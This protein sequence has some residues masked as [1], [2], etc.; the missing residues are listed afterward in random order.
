MWQHHEINNKY[1]KKKEED[2]RGKRKEERRNERKN[3][4]QCDSIMKSTTNTRG[5][6]KRT[7]EGNEKKKEETKKKLGRV[8]FF[9]RCQLI[10][11]VL[12][13]FLFHF[14]CL[15][16]I[17][18]TG[19]RSTQNDLLRWK[20]DEVE[21]ESEV[22]C[23]RWVGRRCADVTAGVLCAR[24]VGRRCADVTAGVQRSSC[25]PKRL[26]GMSLL[27][28]EHWHNLSTILKRC[29]ESY[30]SLFSLYCF[31]KGLSSCKN[32]VESNS[33]NPQSTV[34]IRICCVLRVLNP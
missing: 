23:A 16:R 33:R 17:M 1:K 14:V 34:Y 10:V 13:L 24:W 6:R 12:S 22:L 2:E 30:Y 18:C 9:L 31:C 21:V 8:T 15:E 25:C 3:L 27:E 32:C 26:I 29:H 11:K 20:Q 19:L 28:R 7:K 4:V 5:R